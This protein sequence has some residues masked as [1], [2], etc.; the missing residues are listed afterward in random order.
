M[1][2]EPCR[3]SASE[4]TEDRFSRFALLDWWDQAR[5]QKTKVAVIG[6][7]AL[8][9]EI[10]KNLAL[11]GFEQVVV[12]DSDRI[13][14]SNLSRSVLYR[15]A[16]IGR[17]KAEAAAEAF[18]RIYGRACVTPLC[19][20]IQSGVGMGLFAWA[21]IIVAGLDN[22]EARLWISRS[23]W[24]MGRP[25]VDG[26][27][28]GLGGVARMFLS[29]RPPCY[30]CTL[31]ETDWRILEHRMSCNLLSREEMEAGKVPTT[32]TTASVIAG[33]QVQ[34]ALKYIHG[35]PVLEGKGY[36]FDGMRH[37]SYVVEYTE[38][39]ECL[40]HYSYDRVV[41]LPMTSSQLTLHDLFTTAQRELQA[42]AV[43]LEFSRDII[44]KL[45]CPTCGREE[46]MFVPL[47]GVNREQARCPADG[48]TR[49]VVAIHSYSG[50]E[51]YG[52]RKLSALG[53]PPWDVYA[54]RAGEAEAAFLIAGDEAAV[55]APPGSAVGAPA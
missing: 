15:E 51:D 33:I 18:R 38:N 52:G 25:W 49:A 47:G 23:T 5:I 21:D 34:E 20:N 32:P 35:L 53:L 44:H 30:E 17:P 46:E 41:R 2:S 48:V 28:E 19:A 12:V 9:N 42:G 11:L 54:A 7:G 13:E 27:I 6:A 26:A 45:A 22:R 1:P 43:V 36:V 3:V 24:K 37:L 14:L 55:I 10:L 39:P 50:S 31:G 8:G 4:L 40:G 16:D 29:G